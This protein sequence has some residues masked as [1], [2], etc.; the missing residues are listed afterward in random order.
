MGSTQEFDLVV[1]GSGPGGQKAAIAAAKLGKSVAVIERGRMLGGVCVNTGTIPSKTLREAVVYLTGMSQRELYGS[2][3]RVK[4]RITPAD[5][6]RRTTHVIGREQD[7][8]RNQ[9]LR[10][11]V[12]LFEGHGRFLDPHT[13]V[14]ED[15]THD[16]NVNIKAR[17]VVIATGTKP[18]RPAGVN[19]DEERV[20]DSDGIL[21]LK[22]LPQSMVVVGAGVIGI[23]YA[24]MF[25]ALGTKVTVIE[26]RPTM[27]DFCDS[28]IIESLKFHLRDLAVTF[29]FGEEVTAVDVG[30]GGTLTTLAS[31]K[32]IPA[33][34]VMYSAGRQ[35]Q[36]EHLDVERAG[37]EID[38]RGRIFV[39]DNY[40][41]KVDHIYAVG[42]VIGFP[43]LA[44][45]SMDQGRLAAYH[46]FGEPC[47]GMTDLQPIGIYSIPEVSY[48]GAT[49]VDLT[50]SS[51]PYEVGVSRYRELARGQI[52]GDSYGML[53]LLV[54]TEDLTL[55]GVHIFGSNATELVH[56]GQA[57]MGCG[58]TVEYLVDA[59][60]NYPTFSEAYKVA[61]LDVMNKLRALNQF[62][63]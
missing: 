63:S 23:E 39:D 17:Y 49:E 40:Q 28:E 51:V 33:E 36:T 21:D 12:E 27:L 45:T 43:A 62:K 57:V 56:I 35:G 59:V 29:R 13:L 50:D 48:V 44:A 53:K 30:P 41:T 16:E 61:A 46:A 14:I 32:Q 54:S 10:N 15:P 38:S 2:S 24:S 18:V 25:A 11:G 1:I 7:V 37:L 19:F 55:L 3:Y 58:G 42:D 34:T 31:G 8:V 22:S 5:L 26:K 60:F 9:L 20:L 52:A 6:L 47:K 4:E